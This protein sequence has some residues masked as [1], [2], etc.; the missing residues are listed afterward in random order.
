VTAYAED[1]TQLRRTEADLQQR[2]SRGQEMFD[3]LPETAFEMDPSGRILFINRNGHE[4]FG[5]TAEDVERG[6]YPFKLLAPE[7]RERAQRNMARVLAGERIGPNEYTAILKDG[8]RS[9]FM[10]H[11]QPIV[12]EG[13]S[14]G[15]RGLVV[16]ITDR[17]LAESA[18]ALGEQ[19]FPNV[20]RQPPWPCHNHAGRGLLPAARGPGHL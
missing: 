10:V 5:V 6:F 4:R 1:L 20:Q 18:A 9:V 19:V 7:D 16:D 12:R 11:S 15:L 3:M 17:K 13:R 8:R 14:E 2:E